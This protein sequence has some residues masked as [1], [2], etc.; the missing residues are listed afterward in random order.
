MPQ[1]WLTYEELG[2]LLDCGASAAREFAAER[3]LDRRRCHDGRTRA[4]LDLLLTERW[5]DEAVRHWAGRQIAAC[6]DDLQAVRRLMVAPTAATGVPDRGGTGD[7]GAPAGAVVATDVA[8]A[9]VAPV[10]AE[11]RS[12]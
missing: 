9:D 5:L 8:A 4:K 10:T 1:I 7:T 2:A 12:A 11:R 6:V 3:P